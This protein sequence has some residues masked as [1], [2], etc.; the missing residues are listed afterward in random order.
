MSRAGHGSQ[1]LR[2][3]RRLIRD[4]ATMHSAAAQAGISLG[5]ARL[6]VNEDLRNPPPPEAF[7]PIPSKKDDDI[8]TKKSSEEVTQVHAPDFAKMKRIFLH[9]IAPAEEKTA[10]ERGDL[11]AAWKAIENDCHV[12]RRAA[13][14]LHRLHGESEELRDDFLRSLYGGMRAL[15]IAISQD[16]VDQMGDEE[17]PTMPATAARGMGAE[18]LPGLQ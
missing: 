15:G 9:D 10:K 7:E 4:G 8:M 6:T 12:N 13:K 5:E 11:S 17:A 2:A 3:F 16:L 14:L 1:Q 18:G